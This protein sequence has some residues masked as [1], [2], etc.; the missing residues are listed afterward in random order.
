MMGAMQLRTLCIALAA[1]CGSDPDP[2][3]SDID[4]AMIS[5]SFASLQQDALAVDL[6]ELSFSQDLAFAHDLVAEETDDA[7]IR[8]LMAEEAEESGELAAVRLGQCVTTPFSGSPT[9]EHQLDNCQLHDHTM[10]GTV[11]S[12]WELEDDC[13]RITH[14]GSNLTIDG[15]PTD[16]RLVV[17][18]CDT[19]GFQH[20]RRELV[21]ATQLGETADSI[22]LDGAWT[23]SYDSTTGCVVREGNVETSF[24]QRDTLHRVERGITV[25]NNA[26]DLDV[27]LFGEQLDKIEDGTFELVRFGGRVV[28]SFD[29]ATAIQI[30]SS[31]GDRFVTTQ[32]LD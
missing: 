2:E 25:C 16:L 7:A 10:A 11:F 19:S 6:I 28:V 4:R 15:A 12:T 22:S 23:A 26:T 29:K 18:G 1:G 13:L 27:P 3:L 14:L 24:G 8:K 20:R 9:V 21:M 17:H 31:A 5:D 30:L 32:A